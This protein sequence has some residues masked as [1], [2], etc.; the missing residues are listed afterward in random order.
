[1]K[2]LVLA[3]SILML[4]CGCSHPPSPVIIVTIA[5][6]APPSID[7]GQT[8]QFT[9]SLADDAT[10][11]FNRAVTWSATGPGCSGAAC[12]TFTNVSTNSATYVAPAVGVNDLERYGN[13][14]F[15]CP[16]D[17]VLFG[18]VYRFPAADHRDHQ[19]AHRHADLHLPH[20]S[21]GYRWCNTL[22]LEFGQRHPT[23]GHD[24]EP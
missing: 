18:D 20:R 21:W 13:G 23:H 12:G 2:K 10:N 22:Q 5:P 16:T 3:L 1:M 9:A 8:L 4:M 11:N 14:H 15:R 24:H 6:A 7:Q 17:P 19:S